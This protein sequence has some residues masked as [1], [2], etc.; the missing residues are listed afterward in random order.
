MALSFVAGEVTETAAGSNGRD[1]A[2]GSLGI[3]ALGL[4]VLSSLLVVLAVLPPRLV[5]RTPV[6]RARYARYRE[7]LALAAIGIFASVTVVALLVAFR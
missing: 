4:V 6:A 5:A 3:L 2:N 1:F 7:P